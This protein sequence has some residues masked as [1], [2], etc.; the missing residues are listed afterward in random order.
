MRMKRNLTIAERE[1]LM[2]QIK[3]HKELHSK[4]RIVYMT[5]CSKAALFPGQYMSIIVDGS[6]HKEFPWKKQ[7]PKSFDNKKRLKVG[8]IGL[9]NH[10]RKQ[11]ELYWQ[12]PIWPPDS[13]TIISIIWHHICEVSKQEPLPPTLYVQLDNCYRENKNVYILSFLEWMVQLGIFKKIRLSFMV[14]GHTHCDIDQLHSVW[15]KWLNNHS[16]DTPGDLSLHMT[17]IFQK[18]T[19]TCQ[20]VPVVYDFKEWFIH[21][22]QPT[23]GH[24]EPHCFK[25]AKDSNEKV[26]LWY[27]FFSTDKKWKGGNEQVLRN[28]LIDSPL[29]LSPVKIEAAVLDDLASLLPELETEAG[30]QWFQQLIDHKGL[31]MTA[32][33]SPWYMPPP[34]SRLQKRISQE[35]NW[36]EEE[37]SSREGIVIKTS[38]PKSLVVTASSRI[39]EDECVIVMENDP[40]EEFVADFRVAKVTRTWPNRQVV[41]VVFYTLKHSDPEKYEYEYARSKKSLRQ[42]V[43]KSKLLLHGSHLLTKKDKLQKYAAKKIEKLL[44]KRKS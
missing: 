41:E 44:Q 14:V 42:E 29:P 23:G 6:S 20:F 2:L 9:W 7:L 43:S 11:R 28:K 1:D 10:G 33:V 34:N 15:I 32:P 3:K 25:I 37:E 22:I 4:E 8:C 19:P 18:K 26:C 16:C 35:S 12:L 24:S 40:S 27:K 17:E 30:K 5:R 21:H 39:V 13:N 36:E 38:A 31:N